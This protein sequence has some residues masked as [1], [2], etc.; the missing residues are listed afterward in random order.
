MEM[1]LP[2]HSHQGTVLLSASGAIVLVGDFDCQTR[3]GMLTEKS[4][5]IGLS[6][7]PF[8]FHSIL[9]LLTAM[10]EA[11][12]LNVSVVSLEVRASN[13]VAQHLYRKYRL[14][15]KGVRQGYYRDGEDAWLMEIEVDQDAYR[16]RLTGLRQRLEACLRPQQAGVGQNGRDTL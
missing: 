6:T 14:R 1:R 3:S 12:K 13:R 10:E 9:L 15:F 2:F 7:I 16:A 5:R 4:R 11:L 8:T